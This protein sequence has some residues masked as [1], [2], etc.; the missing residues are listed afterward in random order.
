MASHET[1]QAEFIRLIGAGKLFHGYIFFGESPRASEQCARGLAAQLERGVWDPDAKLL[2]DVHYISEENGAIGI[3]EGRSVA[4]FLSLKPVASPRRT[5][6][7]SSA[8][9]LTMHAQNTILKIT[10]EPPPHALI[11]LTARHPEN[12]LLPLRS[13]LP[14]IYM[15]ERFQAEDIPS[16]KRTEAQRFLGLGPRE[17]SQ[18]LK[19]SL[20]GRIAVEQFVAALLFEFRRRKPVDW[21]AIRKLLRRFELIQRFNVNVRLQLES[22][23]LALPRQ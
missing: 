2:V 17:R 21:D 16:E 20:E 14:Q 11:L 6:I 9:R 10:E 22:V 18:F 5:V 12:L 19:E 4:Q 15:S 3:D 13:R 8:D 1:L 7:V 23:L